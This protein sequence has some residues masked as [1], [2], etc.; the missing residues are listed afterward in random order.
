MPNRRLSGDE[1]VLIFRPLIDQVRAKL[2]NEAAADEELHWA[3]RRKLAKELIYDERG[4]PAHRKK[5]KKL[6]RNEQNGLCA[7]CEEPLPEKRAELDRFEAMVGYTFENTRL[8][9]HACH[10]DDQKRKGYA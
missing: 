10:V 6:K 7:I 3:L 9:C 8:V 2:K 4:N 5:L 1:I